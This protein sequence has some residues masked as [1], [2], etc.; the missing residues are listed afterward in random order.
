MRG[1]LIV[2]RL[3]GRVGYAGAM[4]FCREFYG[5]TDYS[6]R[7]RYRYFRSGFLSK[8]PHVR[9]MRNVVL[10]RRE[11]GP[12]VVDFLKRHKAEVH[13]WAVELRPQDKKVLKLAGRRSSGR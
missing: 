1:R 8:I 2:F 12:K 5:Y 13:E 3:L 11:D 7:G 9:V 10:V 4:R 6:N